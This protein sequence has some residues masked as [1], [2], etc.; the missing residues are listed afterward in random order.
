MRDFS[1]VIFDHSGTSAKT[2]EKAMR[3]I[4]YYL[5]PAGVNLVWGVH[6]SGKRS[7]VFG[8]KVDKGWRVDKEW[9]HETYTEKVPGVDFVLAYFTEFQWRLPH[10]FNRLRGQSIDLYNGTSEMVL[11]G[12]FIK[13]PERALAPNVKDSEFVTRFLHEFCHSMFDHKLFRPDTTHIY[14]YD[15]KNLLEAFNTW[16]FNSMT[17]LA[18]ICRVFIGTDVS[19]KDVVPDSFGCAESISTIIKGILPEFPL[20]TGTWSLLDAIQMSGKFVRI[21]NPERGAIILAVTGQGTGSI[22]NGHAGIMMSDKDIAS[23]NS[24]TGLF[25]VNY[26]LEKWRHRYQKLGGYPNYFFRYTG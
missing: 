18:D 17:N 19:P 3:K 14:H 7:P 4:N 6:Q 10:W 26:T 12:S 5:N 22:P 2:W 24:L 8:E 11:T 21:Q 20:V 16:G 15:R 13:S 9:F 23:N 1:L 25:E